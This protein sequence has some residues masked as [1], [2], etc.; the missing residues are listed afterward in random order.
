MYQRFSRLAMT[1]A[2]AE[3]A[4]ASPRMVD[5]E[6]SGVSSTA[7]RTSPPPTASPNRSKATS[8]TDLAA[9]FSAAGIG[10]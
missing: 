6:E 1:M 8:T 9:R 2:A 10:V 5:D 3:A 7:S 4:I